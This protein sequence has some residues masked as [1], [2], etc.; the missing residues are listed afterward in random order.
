MFKLIIADGPSLP[1]RSQGKEAQAAIRVGFF[2]LVK[3][4]LFPI[5]F[6][7]IW[8]L[9]VAALMCFGLA[10][11][12]CHM[13]GGADDGHGKPVRCAARLCPTADAAG[14]WPAHGHLH[15]V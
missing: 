2:Q 13:Q 11:P 3:K 1:N 12:V 7:L 15:R 5:L 14:I 6:C 4:N 9:G 8:D 10:V